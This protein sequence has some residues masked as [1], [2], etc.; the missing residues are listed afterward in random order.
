MV[1]VGWPS[2]PR[3]TQASNTSSKNR[4][5]V[6]FQLRLW[7]PS[8]S[9]SHSPRCVG[10]TLNGFVR[11]LAHLVG[12]PER[13]RMFGVPGQAQDGID[14]YSRMS[15]GRYA[16]YQCKN[17][18]SVYRKGYTPRRGRLPCRRM[19]IPVRPL[20]V[21]YVGVDGFGA[22]RP[23]RSRRKARVFRNSIHQLRLSEDGPGRAAG[24]V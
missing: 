16:V 7:L 14:V 11:R 21:P 22:S 2:S 3:L 18:T 5:A 9:C 20:R 19:A 13:V 23:N 10:T 15:S 17:G 12:E 4:Q 24:D 1:S 6:R 8:N